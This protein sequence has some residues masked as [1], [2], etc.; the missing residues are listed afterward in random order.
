MGMICI[1]Y[2]LIVVQHLFVV[3]S[4][5]VIVTDKQYYNCVML[6]CVLVTDNAI[7]VLCLRGSRQH[8]K[9]VICVHTC[10]VCDLSYINCLY[11]ATHLS[12]FHGIRRDVC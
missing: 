11:F 10:T 3:F 12:F 6:V 9:C 5:T 2:K 7:N 4:P 8:F 1:F